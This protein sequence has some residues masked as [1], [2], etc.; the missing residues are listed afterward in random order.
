MSRIECVVFDIDDTLYLERDYVRSG[1]A[2]VGRWAA[3]QLGVNDFLDRAW[4]RFE[5]GSRHT[6]FNQVLAECGI[7]ATPDLVELL[8]TLYRAHRPQ[9]ELLPDALAALESLSGRVQLAVLSD[10]PLESQQAKSDALGLARWCAP[11]VLTASLGPGYDKP[12]QLPFTMIEQASSCRGRSCIYVAD[13][14]AKDF[15]APAALGWHTARVRRLQGLRAHMEH[16]EE[17]DVE[18]PDLSG[19]AEVLVLENRD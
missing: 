3:A 11:I 15:F 9:I 1:F 16:G 4:A 10:G 5:K 12:H 2:A 14:P 18:M 6:V 19:L 17:V 7:E 13:N 8:V